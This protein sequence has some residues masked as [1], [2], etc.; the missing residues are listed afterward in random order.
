MPAVRKIHPTRRMHFSVEKTHK[1][2]AIPTRPTFTVSD[3]VALF[4]GDS[5]RVSLHGFGARLDFLN[6]RAEAFPT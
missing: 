5:A 2:F 4:Y 1:Q 3:L 6:R